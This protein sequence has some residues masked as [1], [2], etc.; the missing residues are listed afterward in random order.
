MGNR[1]LHLGDGPAL[2]ATGQQHNIGNHGHHLLEA[3]HQRAAVRLGQQG[4][5]GDGGDAVLLLLQL[6]Y[7]LGQPAHGERVVLV[8]TGQQHRPQPAAHQFH[9]L[10][11]EC[12]DQ[13]LLGGEVVQQGGTAYTAA[14]GDVLQPAGKSV[15]GK[16]L[17]RCLQ[18]LLGGF[19]RAGDAPWSCHVAATPVFNLLYSRL[20]TGRRSG[21]AAASFPTSRAG[22]SPPPET[23][24]L[25]REVDIG[26]TD[27]ARAYPDGENAGR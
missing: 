23:A 26:H 7:F 3:G 6:S 5:Q 21:K 10:A 16:L 22:P 19:G 18:Y 25:A 17:T 20:N 9:Q 4:V 13:C 1:R 14:G 15:Q 2:A 11:H 8:L 12:V 24:G 27:G